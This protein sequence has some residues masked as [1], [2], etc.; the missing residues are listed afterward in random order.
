MADNKDIN[1]ASEVPDGG[2][3][4]T[5]ETTAQPDPVLPPE[6][7]APAQPVLVPRLRDRAWSFRAMLAVA[8]A[9]FL[10]GGLAGGAIVGLTRDDHP[11][12]GRFMIMDGRDGMPPG[13]RMPHRFR[14]GGPQ[15]RWNDGPPPGSGTAPDGQPTNPTPS[16]TPKP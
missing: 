8:A 14:D 9:T 13:W 7:A 3:Q 12:R 2:E 6:T 5:A 1:E 4:P 10:V 11:D 15:W 16:P